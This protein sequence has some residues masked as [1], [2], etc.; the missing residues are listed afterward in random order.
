M[1]FEELGEPC[2]S[3]SDLGCYDRA[4]IEEGGDRP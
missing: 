3:G 4:F 2:A 1:A